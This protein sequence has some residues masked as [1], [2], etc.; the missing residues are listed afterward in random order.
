MELVAR[1]SVVEES[2]DVRVIERAQEADLLKEPATEHEDFLAGQVDWTFPTCAVRA[3]D[4]KEFWVGPDYL[5]DQLHFLSFLGSHWGT[6]DPRFPDDFVAGWTKHT[7]NYSGTVTWDVP[8]NDSGLILEK[9][10]A[11]LTTLRESTPV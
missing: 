3:F 4:K 2:D 5:G 7:N 1:R 10:F 6:G 9:H 11:Q 8:L